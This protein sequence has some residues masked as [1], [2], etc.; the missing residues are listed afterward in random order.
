MTSSPPSASLRAGFPVL[1]NE[2]P[3]LAFTD[4][5]EEHT[6]RLGLLVFGLPGD[7]PAYLLFIQPYSRGEI[8]HAPDAVFLQ[9]HLPNEFKPL[10]QM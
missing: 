7:V 8:P 4:V 5:G 6:Y 1:V 10:A 2:N 3:T 9:V